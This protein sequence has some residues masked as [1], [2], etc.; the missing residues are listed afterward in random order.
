MPGSNMTLCEFA[1]KTTNTLLRIKNM[2]CILH[3]FSEEMV[4]P[5]DGQTHLASGAA[6]AGLA[7]NLAH[8]LFFV[9][10]AISCI[11]RRGPSRRWTAAATASTTRGSSATTAASARSWSAGR[12]RRTRRC[13]A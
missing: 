7:Y 8:F 10:F 4:T 9:H 3:C 5:R 6:V 2:K 12:A 11:H 1:T 13:S